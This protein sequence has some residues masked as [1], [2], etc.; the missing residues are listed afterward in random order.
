MRKHSAAN[1]PFFSFFFNYRDTEYFSLKNSFIT[2]LFCSFQAYYN[3][4][5]QD[6]IHLVLNTKSQNSFAFI[7]NLAHPGTLT[8]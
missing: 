3:P 8:L 7:P 5:K 2:L 4:N 6:Y 1:I